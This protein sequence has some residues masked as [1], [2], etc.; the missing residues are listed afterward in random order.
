MQ[1]QN[2]EKVISLAVRASKMTLSEL[3][4]LMQK[5]LNHEKNRAAAKK[6][7]TVSVPKVYK[8]KQSVKHLMDK[9]EKLTNIEITDENIK[10]FGKIARKYNIDFSLKKDKSLEPPK[11]VVFF[12]AKDMDVFTTAFKEFSEK[13]IK[14]N[15][16]PSIR[17][18]LKSLEQEPAAKAKERTREKH[19]TKEA[20]L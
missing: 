14:K 16:K 2:S 15:M 17:K 3:K 9:G 19:K 4:N 11:Y 6:S 7:H 13:T 10:G 18:R 1:E 5:F 12:K 8:G 20:E